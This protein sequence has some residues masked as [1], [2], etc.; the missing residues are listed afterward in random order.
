MGTRDVVAFVAP[1]E[2]VSLDGGD[3]ATIRRS[4][5]QVMVGRLVSVGSGPHLLPER[6]WY[7]P[8][9]PEYGVPIR[10]ELDSEIGP[11]EPVTVRL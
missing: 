11:D 6:L 1:A 7:N 2:A 3:D 10:I 9:Y 8:T 5:G 4:T